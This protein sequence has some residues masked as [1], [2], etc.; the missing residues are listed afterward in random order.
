MMFPSPEP[1]AAV[2]LA[3]PAIGT[4]TTRVA[5]VLSNADPIA[6]ASRPTKI[7]AI[8]AELNP[9][10]NDPIAGGAMYFPTPAPVPTPA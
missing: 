1:E 10:V 2:G 3:V 7:P 5:K 8:P 6:V 4:G 9:A